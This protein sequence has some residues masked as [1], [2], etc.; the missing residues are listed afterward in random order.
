MQE[1]IQEPSASC[2]PQQDRAG[3][4]KDALSGL[5]S[6]E[7]AEQ[8]IIARLGQLGAQDACAL[9][10]VNLDDFR[11][12]NES[13]G[14]QA[15][16]RAIRRC[17]QLL[18][19][20]FC[21]SDIVGRL[22]NDT[23]L[24]FMSGRISEGLVCQR[25]EAVCRDLQLILEGSPEAELTV[26]AGIG[27]SEGRCSFS[28]LRQS[29]VQALRT[30]K[31]GGKRSYCIRRCQDA[32]GVE[33]P[34][35]VSAVPLASLLE[36]MESGVALLEMGEPI[37]LLYVSPS[38]CRILD[39]SRQAYS[40][41]RALAET[42]HPDDR[43]ELERTLREGVL[44][45]RSLEYTCRISGGGECWRW[46]RLRAVRIQY[47]NPYPVM[48]A[49]L[50]DV[51]RYKEK[52]RRLEETNRRLQIAL[53]QT[54]Q[55]LWEVDPSTGA[56]RIF[57]RTGK[58]VESETPMRFPDWLLS[59]GYIHPSSAPRFRE[60]AAD[61][62]SGRAQGAG[63]FI[64][65]NRTTG[66][67]NWAAVSYRTSYGEDGCGARVVGIVETLPQDS[68]AR[69]AES[70]LH[71][72]LPEALRPDLIV[73]MQANLTHDSV[74]TL[75]MEG[76]G[77]HA[78]LPALTC[79]GIL[80]Q[81]SSALF[82]Q[83]D[84]HRYAACFST[85][86]LLSLFREGNRWLSVEY[87]RVDSGGNIHWVS[88]IANLAEDPLTRDVHLFLYISYLDR[89]HLW[90]QSAR[91]MTLHDGV[92]QL[93]TCNA[94]RAMAQAILDRGGAG[95]CAAAMISLGGLCQLY[96]GNP[97]A[98]DRARFYLA[99]AFTA[100]LGTN[101][102]IALHDPEQILVFFPQAGSQHELRSLLEDAFLFV[103]LALAGALDLEG[104]RFVA[105]VVLERA[106]SASFS[107]MASRSA[108]LCQLWRSAAADTVA[109]PHEGDD[110][111]WMR[112]QEEGPGSRVAV[113]PAQTDRPL[114]GE[115]KDAAFR[116]M[117]AMRSADTLSDSLHGVLSQIGS[118]Y[119]ADR[120]YIL[121]LSD[122]SR[123]VTMP[124]ESG[125]TGGSTASSRRSPVPRWSAT[126]FFCAA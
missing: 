125:P 108:S 19:G 82:Q 57:D 23:F 53:E 111:E 7:T 20:I 104:L 68:A 33:D 31:E 70:I 90:E 122:T 116:C 117:S 77:Q 16:D 9:F 112:L 17:A 43:L 92:T 38:Y 26:S 24:I 120:V 3:A 69:K 4:S 105:G 67:Y 2:S 87:Q 124:Y 21:A 97:S 123:M 103:R 52:E 30:A 32:A 50:T 106:D 29:A 95:G 76:T 56:L 74:Q 65:L 13:L 88:H 6:Q 28:A 99:C 84:R 8:Y 83:E 96:A 66:C 85:Q 72:P 121:T 58:A 5:L 89:L 79:G 94:A 81:C 71:R 35:P 126:R 93:Y 109:F 34:L 115:E 47:S 118:Y 18:S 11:R 107:A 41:P 46:C 44:S 119:C 75:W 42:V 64:A 62:L 101:C 63:N 12:V 110:W 113:H 39:L 48:M 36:N 98:L 100:A 61:L 59:Q 73:G 45:G 37:R 14:R 60:F 86:E 1:S 54:A 22:E 27:F 15:G 55:I 51:S 80:E 91:G 102:L 25:G 114:S 78:G 49:T 10:L 40:L